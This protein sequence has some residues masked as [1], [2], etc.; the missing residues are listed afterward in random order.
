MEMRIRGAMELRVIRHMES[1]LAR[2][3]RWYAAQC[4]GDWEHGAGVKIETLDNPGWLI[5]IDLAGTNLEG[6]DFTSLAEGLE[7]R[8]GF[9][10][11]ASV[12]WHSISLK[13][14]TFEAAGDPAKLEFMLRTFLD[15]AERPGK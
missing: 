12:D 4:N 7:R 13:G 1:T 6:K 2:L 9:D 14:T 11:P 5:K 10:F 15:W 8:E 3:Q